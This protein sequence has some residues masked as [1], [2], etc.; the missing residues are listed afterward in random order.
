MAPASAPVTPDG[1][2]YSTPARVPR[3]AAAAHRMSR[4]QDIFP[5]PLSS[6]DAGSSPFSTLSLNTPQWSDRASSAF[7]TPDSHTGSI[8]SLQAYAASQSPL[9]RRSRGQ[10]MPEDD[11][12]ARA[13][14][15]GIR[16]DRAFDDD[17]NYPAHHEGKR[18][19][20][21][22]EHEFDPL[23]AL[24]V[25]PLAYRRG[26]ADIE[27]E[28]ERM[29]YQSIAPPP[30][31][32]TTPARRTLGSLNTPP[33][34]DDR[35]RAKGS[36]TDPAYPRRRPTYPTSDLFDIDENDHGHQQYPHAFSASHARNRTVD[37]FDEYEI[38][39]PKFYHQRQASFDSMD[40]YQEPQPQLQQ[41]QLQPPAAQVDPAACP[42][43]GN[44]A[45]TLVALAPCAHVLCSACFTSALNIVGEKN[46]ECAV[47]RCAVDNFQMKSAPVSTAAPSQP[48]PQ[49]QP[50]YARPS[51]APR[52]N[53]GKAGSTVLRIDNV[54]WDVTPPMVKAWL[55][56]PGAVKRVHVLLDRKGKTQSHA[57][58]EMRD[59][60]AARAALRTAQ[61]S[62]LGRGK[63]ARGVTVTRTSEDELLAALFP[64]WRGVFEH[65]VPVLR[66]LS[67]TEQLSALAA[68]VLDDTE[69]RALL[70]L[71]RSP[72]S[73]FVKVPSLP[74]HALIS[75]L[76]KLP[77]EGQHGRALHT[78]ARRDALFEAALAAAGVLASD[79]GA[80][81]AT[82]D[83]PGLLAELLDVA[84]QCAIFT[85][86]Q[87]A[88]LRELAE[89]GG[90][91]RAGSAASSASMGTNGGM[92]MMCQGPG[93]DSPSTASSELG[94]G[95]DEF[96]PPGLGGIPYGVNEFG[97]YVPVQQQQQSQTKYVPPHMQGQQRRA[98]A[99]TVPAGLGRA[100]GASHG[101]PSRRAV[102]TSS[103]ARLS[104]LAREFQCDPSLVEA[105][106][107]RL[108]AGEL[109]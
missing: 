7:T 41:Q 93:M 58:V 88:T 83:D 107:A 94:Y 97:E 8:K 78:P 90:G 3:T 29:P 84:S 70:S 37:G 92:P 52:T 79:E 1:K 36:M 22:Y 68:G 42:V 26:R 96:A 13:T 106:A 100:Q 71:V 57:F 77:P 65:G 82:S 66:N 103:Q 73:H 87:R 2:L 91:S 32:P 15:H 20:F 50:T 72:D 54:P 59:E 61:N 25:S 80:R 56:Q 44:R 18:Q 33:R 9:A 35:L 75:V 67:E 19:K 105:V 99:G 12:R 64:S 31:L 85:P 23:A 53:S 5:S 40:E 27:N 63:R 104:A 48:R 6:S 24:G 109:M 69:L 10:G 95:I 30:M 49:Q 28:E 14:E 108:A 102:S 16:V 4:L 86:A 47:C 21:D 38:A 46:M 17:E 51:P 45:S 101:L 39:P 55:K 34:R 89:V 98:S 74:F 81:R 11:W 76:D 60:D 62:V 43:C